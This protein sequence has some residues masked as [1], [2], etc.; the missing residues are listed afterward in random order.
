MKRRDVE[1]LLKKEVNAFDDHDSLAQIKGRL[2]LGGEDRVYVQSDGSAALSRRRNT[3]VVI[4]A[5]LAAAILIAAMSLVFWR[6][7]AKSPSPSHVP[8]FTAKNDV[9]A[10][11]GIST[12][13]LLSEMSG[14]GASSAAL[15]SSSAGSEYGQEAS[16]ELVAE[17]DGYMR[18]V[19]TLINAASTEIAFD[20]L[21]EGEYR[22]RSVT[23]V[24]SA[25]G[26]TVT[27]TM[28]YNEEVIDEEIEEGE[29]ERET[30]IEGV[31]QIGADEFPF[32]GER[33]T[34]KEDGESE[35]EL[36]LTTYLDA[37]GGGTY[38]RFKQEIENDEQSY[39]YEIY[40]NGERTDEFELEI[41]SEDGETEISL[42]KNGVKYE[43]KERRYGS[44]NAITVEYENGG[45][46]YKLV[47][48]PQ[49]DGKYKYYHND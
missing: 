10:L 22:Y 19:D 43:L 41:E 48:V 2:G 38:V 40:E 27:Y 35:M 29:E 45:R 6:Q 16:D 14:A 8:V 49:D 5:A 20:E 36:E 4:I 28:L 12:G 31:M 34:E 30:R 11:A 37:R 15:T 18:L 32:E 7:G 25:N 9:Y 17:L 1:K 47:A 39:A 46:R 23:T 21:T 44:G 33:E 13:E 26:S 42:E 24:S 3:V